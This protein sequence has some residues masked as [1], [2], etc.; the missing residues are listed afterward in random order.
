M[1]GIAGAAGKVTEESYNVVQVMAEAMIH[2]GPD[3]EGFWKYQSPNE[4]YSVAF[5][6]RRLSILDLSDAG[7]QP[8]IDL[9]TGN[10]I[11]F[12]GEIYNFREI[13]SRL[14][15]FGTRFCSESDT[16]VILR[17]FS[18]WGT[19]CFHQL[20]GMFAFAL[21]DRKA[22]CLYLVRDRLGV[23]PLYFSIIKENDGDLIY[24]ASE[25]RALLKGNVV[26]RVLDPIAVRGFLSSGYI[27]G[28]R[29]I[30][31]G[32]RLLPAASFLKLDLRVP[33]D[34]HPRKYW[35]YPDQPAQRTLDFDKVEE[36]FRE[37]VRLRLVSDVP[38]G[39]FLS[40]GTD[41]TAVAAVASQVAPGAIQTFTLGFSETK[42][43]ESQYAE[44]ISRQLGTEHTTIN[45]TKSSFLAD[46]AQGL[47]SLDQPSFDALNTF[48]ISHA[49]R[50]AGLKVAL[51]GVGGD[52]LFGGYRTFS[53]LPFIQSINRQLPPC[54]R[55]GMSA[56]LSSLTRALFVTS[57]P[58]QQGAGKVSDFLTAGPELSQIYGCFYSLFTNDFLYQLLGETG[59][60][61]SGFPEPSLAYQDGVYQDPKSSIL[62]DVSRLE[63]SEYLG[64]RLL[65]DIDSSSMA[66]GL[67]VREPL[68]DH[69]LIQEITKL[70]DALRF[71]PLGTKSFLRHIAKH[72][73]VQISALKTRKAGFELPI[74]MW[75]KSEHQ[76]RVKS[77]LLDSA[78]VKRVGLCPEATARLC[79]AFFSK[80]RNIY[81]SR[82]WAI[83]VL[84]D[85]AERHDAHI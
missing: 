19:D 12:N 60:D 65:R 80:H 18:T 22:S 30:I 37:S 44:Q 35:Y 7:A 63:V 2:R 43:D 74:G 5:S 11:T 24:F 1:C 67:E 13:R 84:I 62:H 70:E 61:D 32:I 46:V 58:P 83:F 79:R 81:W 77:A 53:A 29:T 4:D 39:V 23:K 26:E 85:W 8:M 69:V 82:P 16:E 9:V 34:F 75:L 45:F 57:V 25:V 72:S 31:K 14:E 71:K 78:R 49:V 40:G 27:H 48:F 66:V 68:L 52:E 3:G 64:Q 54:V 6:H 51:A 55:T 36:V 56:A 15:S 42:Y 20:R 10:S 28:P 50:R 17:A 41:S 33:F 73:G 76:E 21:F 38:V 47:S 59:S